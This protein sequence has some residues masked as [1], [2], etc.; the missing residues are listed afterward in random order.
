MAKKSLTHIEMAIES[1]GKALREEDA[2]ERYSLFKYAELRI[3]IADVR[4]R[5]NLASVMDKGL[6]YLGRVLDA[7]L[8]GR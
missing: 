4:A 8:K 6:D 5:Q 1:M 3:S 7:R 2:V